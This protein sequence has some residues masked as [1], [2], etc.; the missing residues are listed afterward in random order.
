MW[1]ELLLAF[2]IV[3]ICVVI[4]ITGVASLT[5]WV[6]RRRSQL[7]QQPLSIN[8]LILIAVFGVVILLHLAEAS[9]WAV[10]YYQRNLFADFETALYFSLKSYTTIGYG[11]VLLPVGWRLLGDIEGLSGVLL[12]GLST[13][14]IFAIVNGILQIKIRQVGKASEPGS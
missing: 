14:F 3:A 11:D 8:N 9:I 10:F 12:C 13:A 1:K 6:L 7:E 5:R 2:A 4:H